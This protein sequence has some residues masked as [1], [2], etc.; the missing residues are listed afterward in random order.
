MAGGRRSGCTHANEFFRKSSRCTRVAH[1]AGRSPPR[2]QR[3]ADERRFSIVQSAV[4]DDE[5]ANVHLVAF[6]VAGVTSD[7]ERHRIRLCKTGCVLLPSHDAICISDDADIV[8]I[9]A[10]VAHI[11]TGTCDLRPVSVVS[12]A[13][14]ERVGVFK[15]GIPSAS[16]RRT[17]VESEHSAPGGIRIEM[18]PR[19]EPVRR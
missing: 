12:V 9:V 15:R 6:A 4:V 11:E 18:V 7:H 17:A 5:F 14:D 13:A 16:G 10:A 2:R 1:R 19:H 8:G 3:L